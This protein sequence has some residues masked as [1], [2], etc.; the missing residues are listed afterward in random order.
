MKV[1]IFAGARQGQGG[2]HPENRRAQEGNG[3]TVWP[4]ARDVRTSFT[5]TGSALD[6]RLSSVVRSGRPGARLR[7]SVLGRLGMAGIGPSIVTDKLLLVM[8]RALALCDVNRRAS[9]CFPLL[10]LERAW[11]GAEAGNEGL[12][13]NSGE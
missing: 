6:P 8:S 5:A 2:E 4:V 3:A 1:V 10:S 7:L 9:P 12:V 13:P 11:S